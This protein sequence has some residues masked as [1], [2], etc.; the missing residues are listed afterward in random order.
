MS[1]ELLA[2]TREMLAE[3]RKAT[4]LMVGS[5]RMI[6]ETSEVV[7]D[8]HVLVNSE[9]TASIQRELNSAR[10]ELILLTELGRPEKVIKA[11]EA[12]IEELERTLVEREAADRRLER[13]P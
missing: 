2:V 9:K 10:R 7:R 12:A 5:S 8:I 1:D 13:G 11:T 4:E 3:Y 6:R